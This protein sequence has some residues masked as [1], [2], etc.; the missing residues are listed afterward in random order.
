MCAPVTNLSLLRGQK[1]EKKKKTQSPN[2]DKELNAMSP[3]GVQ[4]A[5]MGNLQIMGWATVD[6][7]LDIETKSLRAQ[8]I[9]RSCSQRLPCDE[10][11]EVAAANKSYS[12]KCATQTYFAQNTA[13]LLMI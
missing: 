4:T 1:E 10:Q 5:F 2:K 6:L 3:E 12:S 11:L 13:A 7:S 8:S 9:R